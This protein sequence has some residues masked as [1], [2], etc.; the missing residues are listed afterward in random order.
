ML[1]DGVSVVGVDVIF[2]VQVKSGD[3]SFDLFIVDM[4]VHEPSSLEQDGFVQDGSYDPYSS[5]QIVLERVL[6][7]RNDRDQH[8]KKDLSKVE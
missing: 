1:H 4:L 3:V 2:A 5:A 8:E 6:S 7:N